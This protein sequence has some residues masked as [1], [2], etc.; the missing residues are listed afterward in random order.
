MAKALA[1]V[2]ARS[3]QLCACPLSI[4]QQPALV[5]SFPPPHPHLHPRHQLRLNS[6]HSILV[7]YISKLSTCLSVVTHHPFP[8]T[9]YF[10]HIAATLF[11]C[12]C[13]D[14]PYFCHYFASFTVL[15]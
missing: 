6:F 8:V 2:I 9:I 14:L 15:F 3:V 12:V 13:S 7:S 1:G 11:F 5:F 4:V 10:I